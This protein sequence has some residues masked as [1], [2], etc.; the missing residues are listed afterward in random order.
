MTV[1]IAFELSPVVADLSQAVTAN[2]QNLILEKHGVVD[3]LVGHIV[4]GGD[5]DEFAFN[6]GLNE[7][8]LMSLITRN[9]NG[10]LKVLT[11]MG[12]G[13]AVKSAASLM[14]LND[15]E[16]GAWDA[17]VTNYAAHHRAVMSNAVD[18]LAKSEAVYNPVSAQSGIIVYNK[19]IIASEQTTE[20]PEL[21]PELVGSIVDEQ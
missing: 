20:I 6:L 4:A 3:M 15:L 16:R 13:L 1:P 10:Q 21:P 12:T 14:S 9:R 8:S 2:D 19:N 18:T 17:S 11:A 5:I 7:K